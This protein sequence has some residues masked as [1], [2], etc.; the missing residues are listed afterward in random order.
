MNNLYKGPVIKLVGKRVL[1]CLIYGVA[2]VV[3]Q[4]IWR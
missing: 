3:T 1:S 2:S 4:K